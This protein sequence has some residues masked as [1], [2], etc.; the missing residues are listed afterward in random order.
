MRTK[1]QFLNNLK[2]NK[3]DLLYQKVRYVKV[4]NVRYFAFEEPT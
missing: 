3:K 1:V 2:T 4:R